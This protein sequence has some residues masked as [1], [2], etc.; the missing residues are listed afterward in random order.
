MILKHY[1]NLYGIRKTDFAKQLGLTPQSIYNFSSGR[2]KPH[3]SIQLAI[4]Y[5]SGG[6][7]APSDWNKNQN[8]TPEESLK[9]GF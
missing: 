8:I 2:K 1:L 7:V 3:Y 9:N 6:K 4:E 5:I